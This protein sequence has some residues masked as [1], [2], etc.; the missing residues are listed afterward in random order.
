MLVKDLLK[1]WSF[2]KERLIPNNGKITFCV[3]NTNQ[4]CVCSFDHIPPKILEKECIREYTFKND[5][6]VIISI[7][8]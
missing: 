1:S 4:K 6:L 2:I 3:K 5:A 8:G 7:G